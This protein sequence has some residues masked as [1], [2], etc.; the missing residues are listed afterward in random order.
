MTPSDPLPVAEEE[1]ND[2]ERELTILRARDQGWSLEC[3]ELRERLAKAEEALR[4][5]ADKLKSL[6]TDG[7]YPPLRKDGGAMEM[8]IR[9]SDLRA[10]AAYFAG[11]PD[12]TVRTAQLE[13]ELKQV[14]EDFAELNQSYTDLIVEARLRACGEDRPVQCLRRSDRG[15][16]ED[17]RR[18]HHRNVPI[19]QRAHHVVRNQCLAE[20]A[21]RWQP[22]FA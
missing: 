21:G 16:G 19:R 7:D 3:E 14:K 17:S 9:I 4:P 20:G 11:S 2:R 18:T 5:F 12:D 10:A 1:P 8:N 13:A 15:G 6:E 22:Q